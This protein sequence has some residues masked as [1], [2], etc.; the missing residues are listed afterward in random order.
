[1]TTPADFPAAVQF[2]NVSARDIIIRDIHQII[3]P[4]RD[5]VRELVLSVGQHLG[6]ETAR[7]LDALGVEV[8]E[9]RA[10]VERFLQSLREQSVPFDEV[11]TKLAEIAVRRRMLDKLAVLDLAGQ[12]DGE[13]ADEARTAID[14]GD[15]DRASRLLS[16]LP[17]VRSVA[18]ND[19]DLDAELVSAS[20]NLSETLP[21]RLLALALS[22]SP[23]SVEEL[24]AALS[25]VNTAAVVDRMRQRRAGLAQERAAL[26]RQASALK[27]EQSKLTSRI[28]SIQRTGPPVR[29]VA[30][31]PANVTDEMRR[32]STDRYFAALREY[33]AGLVRYQAGQAELGPLEEALASLERSRLELDS[34]IAT[35]T[36]KEEAAEREH[37]ED[38]AK[39][40]DRDMD[41]ALQRT[42]GNSATAYAGKK[43]FKGFWT[44][45]GAN[46]L[47]NLFRKEIR[48][49]AVVANV[50]QA[51]TR[52]ANALVDATRINLDAIARASLLAPLTIGRALTVNKSELAALAARLNGVPPDQFKKRHRSVQGLLGTRLPDIPAYRHLEASAE[53]QEMTNRLRTLLA[54]KQ[55]YLEGVRDALA[56]EPAELRRQADDGLVDADAALARLHET[57]ARHAGVLRPSHDFWKMVGAVNRDANLPKYIRVLCAS[58]LQDVSRRLGTSV[59][60]LIAEATQSNFALKQAEE[61][62]GQHYLTTHVAD[63][64]ALTQRL[65]DSEK[66]VEMVE[67]ALED[68]GKQTDRVASRYRL[69]LKNSAILALLPFVGII[70]S[71]YA[72]V[73]L[74]K[75]RPLVVSDEPSYVQLAAYGVRSMAW[76]I[77][78][79]GSATAIA[80]AVVY[81]YPDPINPYPLIAAFTYLLGSIGA[82]CNFWVLKGHVRTRQ[83]NSAK[84]SVKA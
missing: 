43:P 51:F 76:G 80:G 64:R 69:R 61:Y 39:A 16:D 31:N 28:E 72:A 54:N 63:R 75:M 44:L 13:N 52:T 15:Y 2:E 37:S 50:E 1:M 79:T 38:L 21:P 81:V 6:G 18:I 55:S 11:P 35:Q 3:G 49:P 73:I 78:A 10:T 25:G 26:E 62:V 27:S 77:L 67:A 19:R 17:D 71:I 40:R 65:S 5:E 23:P 7:K 74:Y 45:L 36:T 29:P 8:G 24:D 83:R 32:V 4:T 60:A 58:L 48:D 12:V 59:D 41:L 70:A 57:C 20:L 82:I 66:A 9:T 34:R 46:C 33:E 84:R 53:I 47:L 30:P 14:A 22:P 42:L 68:I 56:N